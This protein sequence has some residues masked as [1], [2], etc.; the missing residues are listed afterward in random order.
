MEEPLRFIVSYSAPREGWDNPGV[1]KTRRVREMTSARERRQTI[2]RGLRLLPVDQHGLRVRV[3]SVNRLYVF[4][5][6]HIDNA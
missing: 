2:G 5:N 6:C 1:L 4:A 3:E